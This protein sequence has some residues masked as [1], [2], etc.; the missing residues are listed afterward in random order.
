VIDP[1]GP[2]SIDATFQLM[3]QVT[4]YQT[5][6]ARMDWI[7]QTP[8]PTLKAPGESGNILNSAGCRRVLSP[9]AA[10]CD[11][12]RL[13]A[14]E[15]WHRFTAY[16]PR[17]TV[18]GMFPVDGAETAFLGWDGTCILSGFYGGGVCSLTT[19]DVSNGPILLTLRYQWW[20]CGGETSDH[21]IAGMGC[22]KMGGEPPEGAGSRE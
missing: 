9:P 2:T 7:T 3:T 11:S 8:S 14:G 19:P 13:I 6:A 4:V 1:G 5:G 12:V 10:P 18:V 22:V 17:Q 16:V 20:D 21:N 15:P